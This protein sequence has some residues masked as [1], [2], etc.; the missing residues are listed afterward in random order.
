MATQDDMGL[1]KTLTT[2]ALVLKQRQH[3]KVRTYA[4][5]KTNP[6]VRYILLRTHYRRWST[7]ESLLERYSRL[8]PQKRHRGCFRLPHT[9][10]MMCKNR[11]GR[12]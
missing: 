4:A 11:S 6:G 10:C 2:I 8:Y 7:S 3:Y 12:L 9:G 1:G 5:S